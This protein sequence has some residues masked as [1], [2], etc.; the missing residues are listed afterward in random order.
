MS[1][2]YGNKDSL[3]KGAHS[4]RKRA[5][6]DKEIK[7]LLLI[8]CISRVLYMGSDFSEELLEIDPNKIGFGALTLG[9]I[10]NNGDSFLEVYN[11]TAV[12]CTIHDD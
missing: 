3:L 6:N 2:L 11:K 5:E 8:D 10:A 1:V 7:D 9:E 4:A 12:V